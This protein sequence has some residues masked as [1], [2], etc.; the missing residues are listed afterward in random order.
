MARSGLD[1]LRRVFFLYRFLFI[2][3]VLDRKS[4]DK[5]NSP[6]KQ[7]S[8]TDVENCQH[9]NLRTDEID[10]AVKSARSIGKVSVTLN[11]K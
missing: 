8:F 11:F 5:E 6:K 2:H 1:D 10:L 7:K 4:Y 3:R 9:S